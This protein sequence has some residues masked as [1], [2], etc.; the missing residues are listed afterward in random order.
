MKQFFR[1]RISLNILTVRICKLE[2]KSSYIIILALSDYDQIHHLKVLVQEKSSKN[3]MKNSTHAQP[4]SIFSRQMWQYREN[5]VCSACSSFSWQMF[6]MFIFSIK[7]K[8]TKKL[9]AIFPQFDN[10]DFG[11]HVD[12]TC[13]FCKIKSE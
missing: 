4:V 3:S 12:K 13:F 5:K 9:S 10:C 1:I 6:I 2:K 7:K 11:T 8:N